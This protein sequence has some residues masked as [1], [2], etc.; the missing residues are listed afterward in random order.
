[1]DFALTEEQEM[2]Q[3]STREFLEIECPKPLVRDM[4]ADEIGH[5][6]ELWQKMADL[7]WLG[8]LFPEQYG[9]ADFSFLDMAILLEEMGRA[10]LPGPYFSTVVLC[11]QAILD[12]GT[13]E[14][15]ANFLERIAAGELVMALAFTETSASYQ[16]SDIAVR[17]DLSGDSYVINGTK[18]F[19][20]D[21]QAADYFMVV[22][23]TAEGPN[24]QEGISTYLNEMCCVQ[25]SKRTFSPYIFS[26]TS[27]Y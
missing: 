4:E 25:S 2:L 14:Q 10:L 12:A 22:A 1:M 16:A 18:M 20:S 23:R 17:A 21:G 9:G 13:D 19:V 11:G 27:Y 15:K 5:S 24:P 8:L 7:G 3:T 6:P 26:A